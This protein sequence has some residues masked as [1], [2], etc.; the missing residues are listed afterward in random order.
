MASSF[1]FDFAGVFVCHEYM[2]PWTVKVPFRVLGFYIRVW[3][4]GCLV[5]DYYFGTVVV[6]A[7]NTRYPTC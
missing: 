5:E 2:Y 1:G 6:H 7:L 4:A 3:A